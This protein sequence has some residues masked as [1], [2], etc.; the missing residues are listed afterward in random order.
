M[1][2]GRPVVATDLDVLHEVLGPLGRFAPAGDARKFA[3]QLAAVAGTP[4]GERSTL[5]HALRRR[6]IDHFDPAETT[7]RL[8]RVYE[9]IVRSG[10]H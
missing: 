4:A 1:A 10:A 3:D 5:A 2:C 7:E 6:A 8:L 9:D